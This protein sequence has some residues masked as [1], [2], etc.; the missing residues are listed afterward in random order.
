MFKKNPS[1]L[2]LYVCASDLIHDFFI[3]PNKYSIANN[4]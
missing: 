4:R 3:E 2:L 1:I